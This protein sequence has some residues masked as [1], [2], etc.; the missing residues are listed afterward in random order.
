MGD[1]MRA[2]NNQKQGRSVG[3][4]ILYWV[5]EIAVAVGI[6]LLIIQ[7]IRP[8]V[9]RETSM[10]P[11]FQ[12]GNYLF[13]YRLAYKGGKTP[14]KGDVIIFKS[15][16]TTAN[17]KPK[18]LIKRVI[19]MPGDK[20]TIQD[21]KVWINGKED[22]QSYTHDKET[23]SVKTNYVVPKN[24][25]F[26]MGDNRLVSIDSRYASVGSVAKNKIVGKVV[27]R[28]FPFSEIGTIKN[29]YKSN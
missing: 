20:I 22:K 14:Q 12:D 29:P 6:A 16:L 10:L 8:T 28:L 13:V 25:Y 7:V 23:N 24:H 9:V 4:A 17:G 11:N 26:C 27:F 2:E 5:I 19:G 3:K 21:G 15:K 18:M 1:I